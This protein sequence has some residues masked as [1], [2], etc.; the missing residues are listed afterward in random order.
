MRARRR[1]REGGHGKIEALRQEARRDLGVAA[2][3]LLEALGA[4]RDMD[5]AH[6]RAFVG[7]LVLVEGLQ[8]LTTIRKTLTPP[9]D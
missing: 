8:E 7:C 3:C 6:A 4:Q 2:H 5:D 1:T 9:K